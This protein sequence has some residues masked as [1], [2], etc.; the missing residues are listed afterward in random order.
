[1]RRTVLSCTTLAIALG[2]SAGPP[3]GATGSG[4]APPAAMQQSI[5]VEAVRAD[6]SGVEGRVVNRNDEPVTD[7]RLLVRD[8]FRWRNEFAPGRDDPGTAEEVVVS[9][10]IAPGASA[11]FRL[12][13]SR[14]DRRDGRFE[15][16]VEVLGFVERP[17]R[18]W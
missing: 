6:D 1:M 17:Q 18:A 12:D 11:P 14:P 8:S 7:V 15:T 13:R 4:F 16:A 5:A 9:G 3:A 10:P 2:G